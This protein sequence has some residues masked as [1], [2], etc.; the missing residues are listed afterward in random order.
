MQR[1]FRLDIETGANDYLSTP[2][3][4]VLPDSLMPVLNIVLGEGWIDNVHGTEASSYAGTLDKALQNLRDRRQ[5]ASLAEAQQAL[6]PQA[7]AYTEN[8]R[9]LCRAHPRCTVSVLP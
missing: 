4:P 1:Q 6:R 5:F 9:D 2:L 7:E 3:T 8:L